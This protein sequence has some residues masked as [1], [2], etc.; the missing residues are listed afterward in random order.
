MPMTTSPEM[1]AEDDELRSEYDV[2]DLQGPVRGKYAAKHQF[3]LP[4]DS[5][6]AASI[7]DDAAAELTEAHRQDLRRRLEAYC[8]NPAAGRP[9]KDVRS[10]L[11]GPAKIR[12][13]AGD[14]VADQL[15]P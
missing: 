11:L 5:E 6:I 14:S 13:G 15:D 3:D 7:P 9:W 1:S 4:A 10:D 2:R 8:E 12:P